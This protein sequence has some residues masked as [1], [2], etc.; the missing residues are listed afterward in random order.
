MSSFQE[1][2]NQHKEQKRAIT[3]QQEEQ[4]RRLDSTIPVIY[5]IMFTDIKESFSYNRWRDQSSFYKARKDDIG[6]LGNCIDW[7]FKSC[8]L[9]W[10]NKERAE[11]ELENFTD[12][13]E[14]DGE[15]KDFFLGS[16]SAPK[17]TAIK[18]DDDSGILL[19]NELA[20]QIFS[21]TDFSLQRS[22][23]SEEKSGDPVVEIVSAVLSLLEHIHL[24]YGLSPFYRK[25]DKSA[26]DIATCI[27]CGC[28]DNKKNPYGI[29]INASNI[30][31]FFEDIKTFINQEELLKKPGTR[32]MFFKNPQY[33][34]TPQQAAAY[35]SNAKDVELRL[36]D[37]QYGYS[38]DAAEK[39][40]EKCKQRYPSISAMAYICG[41]C[42]ENAANAEVFVC[43]ECDECFCTK[44]TPVKRSIKQHKTY[45]SNDTYSIYG[46]YECP[47]CGAHNDSTLHS[48]NINF[49]IKDATLEE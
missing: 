3:K 26:H 7:D 43:D 21:K 37:G 41:R 29:N 33:D 45:K 13:V 18:T 12:N 6:N 25:D 47:I 30:S 34:G 10:L 28:P 48:A 42:G 14:E 5:G 9:D 20:A 11:N 16:H 39:I 19:M 49:L 4:Q 23:F 24:H 17:S 40:I 15:L 22:I 36:R 1:R 35:H 2:M 38:S 27:I 46:V 31:A 44:C 32:G 8:F